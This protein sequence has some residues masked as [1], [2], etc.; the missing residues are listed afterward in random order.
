M[1]MN[2]LDPDVAEKFEEDAHMGYVGGGTNLS[3]RYGGYAVVACSVL[4][5]ELRRGADQRP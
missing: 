1:L 5:A 3:R 4:P 2:N